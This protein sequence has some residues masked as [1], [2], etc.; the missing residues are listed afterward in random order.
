MLYFMEK[1]Y[2]SMD[3]FFLGGRVPPIG[4]GKLHIGGQLKRGATSDGDPVTCSAKNVRR[5]EARDI[6][7]NMK[8]TEEKH[9]NNNVSV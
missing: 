7:N 9:K 8:Q 3:S 1:S 2:E 5:Q 4:F 6:G